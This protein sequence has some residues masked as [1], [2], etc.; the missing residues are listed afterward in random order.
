MYECLNTKF[1][2]MNV[3]NLHSVRIQYVHVQYVNTVHYCT[4]SNKARTTE[5]RVCRNSYCGYAGTDRGIATVGMK[6]QIEE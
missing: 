4:Y 5:R 2:S 3:Y 6:E 1:L